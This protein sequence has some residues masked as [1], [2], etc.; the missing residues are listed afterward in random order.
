MSL[1]YK[2]HFASDDPLRVGDHDERIGE[3]A[4]LPFMGWFGYFFETKL[5]F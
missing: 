5:I 4:E 1:H 2:T 3:I